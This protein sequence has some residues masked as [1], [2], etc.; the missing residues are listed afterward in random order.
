[1]ILSVILIKCD[2]FLDEYLP[3]VIRLID[4]EIQPEQACAFLKLCP[5]SVIHDVYKREFVNKLATK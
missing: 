1:M 2:A 4:A 5:K 3:E